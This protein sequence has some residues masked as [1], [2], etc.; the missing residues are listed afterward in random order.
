MELHWVVAISE[1]GKVLINRKMPNTPS[2]IGELIGELQALDVDVTVGVDITAGIA[3]LLAGRRAGLAR[4][5]LLS[6]GRE[7]LT[8]RAVRSVG[9]RARFGERRH[10]AR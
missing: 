4:R 5:V 9:G 10:G 8:R 3:G 6:I 2:A 1:D 7:R